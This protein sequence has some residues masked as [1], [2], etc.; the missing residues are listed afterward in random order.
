MSPR[1][2][3]LIPAALAALLLTITSV[4]ITAQENLTVNA[5]VDNRQNA[6]ALTNANLYRGG[7]DVLT[8]GTLLIRDGRIV[9]VGSAS[10]S[11][12]GYFVVDLKGHYVY[13]GLID[14]YS[15]Y[16][17]SELE[18]EAGTPG[19]E[20]LYADDRALNVNDAIR[21]NFRAS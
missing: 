12:N 17:I 20:N 18:R 13:P 15:T 16:G 21:A 19:V 3:G 10:L 5:I 7:G 4:H 6:Y 14:I 2:P 9:D 11:T 8:N 1:V